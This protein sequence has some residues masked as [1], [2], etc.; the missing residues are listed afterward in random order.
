MSRTESQE[1]RFERGLQWA[2]TIS[3]IC[4]VSL[5]CMKTVCAITTLSLSVTASALD[6]FLDVFV[7]ML[8][9][10]AQR[11][12]KHKDKENYPAGMNRFEPIAV[13]LSSAVM[14]MGA[15]EMCFEST[16]TIIRGLSSHDTG[17]N[18]T[19]LSLAIL[20]CGIIV[21]VCLYLYCR[22]F[23]ASPTGDALATDHLNDMVSN[24]VAIVVAV[25]AQLYP[26]LWFIDPV[27][28]IAISIYIVATWYQVAKEHTEMLV[29]RAADET[30]VDKIKHISNN[31]HESLVLDIVRAY[32]FGTRF[33]VEL[34]VVLP[35][36]M[37]VHEAHDISL[38]LQQKVER[39]EEVER[40]FCHVDYSKR[41]VDEHDHSEYE[42]SL[43]LRKA[44][45][46]ME[47]LKI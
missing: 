6:S 10:A 21:K 31:F 11:K 16:E 34:E 42:H 33:L 5:M 8:L 15:L 19:F 45:A 26:S 14:G 4:N 18:I 27:G 35:R 40:A 29:G 24:G 20:L 2:A 30:F 3:V 43:R 28:A 44:H 38:S 23:R 39:L 9:W 7:Q 22:H 12:T 36:D 41:T 37:P 1:E 17:L 46:N 25:I 13:V 47:P 32:H